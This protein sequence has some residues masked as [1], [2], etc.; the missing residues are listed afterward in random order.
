MRSSDPN[1]RQSADSWKLGSPAPKK[2]HGHGPSKKIFRSCFF[3][4]SEVAFSQNQGKRV[5]WIKVPHLRSSVLASQ[6]LEFCLWERVSCSFSLLHSPYSLS[7]FE[8]HSDSSLQEFHGPFC[9]RFLRAM[10]F[11]CFFLTPTF[12]EIRLPSDRVY[13]LFKHLVIRGVRCNM[14]PF[15][16]L[17]ASHE[18]RLT[19]SKPGRS[20]KC[21]WKARNFSEQC[22]VKTPWSPAQRIPPTHCRK[23]WQFITALQFGSQI[24]SYAAI[25]ENS[26]SESSSGQ[27]MGKNWRKYRH[28]SW[29]KSE[30]KKRWAMKQGEKAKKCILLLRWISV[31]SRIRSWNQ[32]FKSIKV[33]LC[34]EVVKWKVIQDRMRRK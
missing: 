11:F 4:F 13:L 7:I 10:N 14:L 30:I 25:Y 22:G 33:E 2:F 3:C 17:S 6:N 9:G 5:F 24:Y 21:A 20:Q 8:L 19:V 29:R 28:G 26:C 32:S 16:V 31:I 15:H 1:F 23:R 12:R 27:G 34:S 18:S